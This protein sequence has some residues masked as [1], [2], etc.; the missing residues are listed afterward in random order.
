MTDVYETPARMVRTGQVIKVAVYGYR[1]G[2]E[3][4][5][6][7]YAVHPYWRSVEVEI[8]DGAP[9][10]HEDGDR[11]IAVWFTGWTDGGVRVERGWG[12][13]PNTLVLVAE[14]RRLHCYGT[15]QTADA[16]DLAYLLNQIGDRTS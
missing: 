15:V 4:E 6:V 3:V 1:I 8:V 13:R 11:G 9:H 14:D 16:S 7:H 10:I 2:L 5:I 12:Q